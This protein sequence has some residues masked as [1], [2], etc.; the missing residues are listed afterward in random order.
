MFPQG[1]GIAGGFGAGRTTL[2][3]PNLSR[4]TRNV[5]MKEYDL[6]NNEFWVGG[7]PATFATK[8]EKPWKESLINTMISCNRGNYCGSI[9]GNCDSV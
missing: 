7:V 3:E 6:E 2:P 1:R 8:G 9:W 4:G 5:N